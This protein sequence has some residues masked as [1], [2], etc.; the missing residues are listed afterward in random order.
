V[1]ICR[2]RAAADRSQKDGLESRPW[3]VVLLAAYIHIPLSGPD[4]ARLTDHKG[5]VSTIILWSFRRHVMIHILSTSP[6]AVDFASELASSAVLL[7]AGHCSAG[8]WSLRR[9]LRGGF[10]FDMTTKLWLNF[11]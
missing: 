9:V 1:D 11:Q 3:F 10:N 5:V 2:G 7:A 6:L 4:I 8:C